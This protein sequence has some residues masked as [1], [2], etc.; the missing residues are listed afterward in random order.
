MKQW[1]Y[2]G[3]LMAILFSS[4]S[5]FKKGSQLKKLSQLEKSLDSISFAWKKV[6][7]VQTIK[8]LNNCENTI[9]S[10]TERYNNQVLT[11]SVARNL[12]RFKGC[13]SMFRVLKTI[14]IFFFY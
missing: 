12:D 14:R 4:C 6:D 13:W 8:L 10:I 2:I 9:D 5:D 3:L 7:T 1:F 11:L